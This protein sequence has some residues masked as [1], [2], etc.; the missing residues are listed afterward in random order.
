MRFL[1]AGFATAPDFFIIKN[2]VIYNYNMEGSTVG[3]WYLRTSEFCAQ[4]I[5]FFIIGKNVYKSFNRGKAAI[6]RGYLQNA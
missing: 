3:V 6:K 4:S 2:R 5:T 1:Y